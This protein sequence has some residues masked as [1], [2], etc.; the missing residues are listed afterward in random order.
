MRGQSIGAIALVLDIPV[1][2]LRDEYV[3]FL[4]RLKPMMCCLGLAGQTR[5]EIGQIEIKHD[6]NI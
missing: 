4:S 2:S 5:G 3:F 6:A 1:C